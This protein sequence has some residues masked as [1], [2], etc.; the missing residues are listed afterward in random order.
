MSVSYVFMGDNNIIYTAWAYFNN[1]LHLESILPFPSIFTSS[2]ILSFCYPWGD[3]IPNLT[4][5]ET[6]QNRLRGLNKA[7]KSINNKTK[8]IVPWQCT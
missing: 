4:D 1:T 5:E 8:I 3:R 6:D 2:F 7:E